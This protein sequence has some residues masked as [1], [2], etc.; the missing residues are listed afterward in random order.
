MSDTTPWLQRVAVLIFSCMSLLACTP[1]EGRGGYAQ[2]KGVV[3]VRDW[4]ASFTLIQDTFPA[5]DERIYLIY[6]DEGV[7]GTDV[8]TSFDGRY[9]FDQLHP[10][11]YTIYA[12]SDRKPT[13]DNTSS[14][15]AV[16]LKVHLTD[17]RTQHQADTIWIN[18]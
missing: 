14:T 16:V 11:H 7:P 6:G 15:E 5:M 2:I 13:P 10:G 12:Y 8:R 3:M 17:K 9:R 1:D 18:R 4:N